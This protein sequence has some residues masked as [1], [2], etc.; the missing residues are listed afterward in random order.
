MPNLVSI[1][2]PGQKNVKKI[3]D[4]IRPQIVTSLS[5]F[6]FMTNLEQSGNRIPDA[7]AIKLAFSLI[8]TFYLIKTKNRTKNSLTQISHYW[9][10]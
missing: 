2:F 9:F 4:N 3:D 8:V 10:A 5:F 1:T 7:S 6:R